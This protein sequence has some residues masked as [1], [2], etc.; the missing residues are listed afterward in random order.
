MNQNKRPNIIFFTLFTRTDESYFYIS[1]HEVNFLRQGNFSERILIMDTIHPVSHSEL[2]LLLEKEQ[3]P[4]VAIVG[5]PSVVRAISKEYYGEDLGLITTEKQCKTD[6]EKTPISKEVYCAMRTRGYAII[7][8]FSGPFSTYL[9]AK[10]T[11]AK[12][13][14]YA[15]VF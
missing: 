11:V 8:P 4:N 6:R 14:H 1:S 7:A 10:E 13:V 2:F 15:H 9:A 3:R 12:Q 5:V